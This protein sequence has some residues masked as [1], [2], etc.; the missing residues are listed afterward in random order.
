VSLTTDEKEAMLRDIRDGVRLIAA[1][2]AEPLRKRLD[3]EFLTSAQRRKM[4]R[5][6]D[7]T[8][9]YEQIA[10]SAGVTA[11]AVR[12]FAVALQQ[13]GLVTLEKQGSKTCPRKLLSSNS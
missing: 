8:R 5:E 12:Q 9:P 13:V 7:G 1:A 3:E 2:M 11:E 6:F 4:Y 10:S